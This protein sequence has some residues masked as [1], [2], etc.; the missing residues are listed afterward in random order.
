MNNT[1]NN[2]D[3]TDTHF[4]LTA[5]VAELHSWS[6]RMGGARNGNPL[7]SSRTWIARRTLHVLELAA[8]REDF[9]GGQRE[10]V[11]SWASIWA[12]RCD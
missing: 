11:S 10:L 6:L 5:T 8:G 7:Q 9:S 2:T 3:A 12:R 1:S 4:A